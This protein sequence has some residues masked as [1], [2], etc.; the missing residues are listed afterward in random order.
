MFHVV[1]KPS[2]K[3]VENVLIDLVNFNENVIVDFLVL[4]HDPSKYG[5]ANSKFK[6]FPVEDMIKNSQANILFYC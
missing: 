6:G 1:E 5:K 3:G 2:G 4:G